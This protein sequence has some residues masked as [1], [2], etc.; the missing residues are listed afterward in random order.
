MILWFSGNLEICNLFIF[1]PHSSGRHGRVTCWA[2]CRLQVTLL[3]WAGRCWAAGE[4]EP[5]DV[6]GKKKKFPC[7]LSLTQHPPLG[8]LMDLIPYHQMLNWAGLGLKTLPGISA[9]TSQP[10]PLPLPWAV[11]THTL[12]AQKIVQCNIWTFL[13]FVENSGYFRW[14]KNDALPPVRLHSM[15][16]GSLGGV[17]LAGGSEPA[18]NSGHK[19]KIQMDSRHCVLTWEGSQRVKPAYTKA[20]YFSDNWVDAEI[21]LYDFLW[22]ITG[23]VSF[24]SSSKNIACNAVIWNAKRHTGGAQTD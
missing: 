21:N 9:R 19:S 23:I 8:T 17:C 18:L 6:I 20:I 16:S 5:R 1:S 15:K 10:L 24:F 4:L 2:R 13:L 14:Q 22:N 7:F 3:S 12:R 11:V